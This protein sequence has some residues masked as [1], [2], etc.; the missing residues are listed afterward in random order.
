MYYKSMCVSR[1]FTGL[2]VCWSN[3]QHPSSCISI[4][5]CVRDVSGHYEAG[6]CTMN[7]IFLFWFW[8]YDLIY[9]LPFKIKVE[10]ITGWK[11]TFLHIILRKYFLIFFTYFENLMQNILIIFLPLLKLLPVLPYLP[12]DPTSCSFT[13][14]NT[15]KT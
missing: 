11:K 7:S 15:A 8:T 13:L 2:V 5:N 6:R 4:K 10:N 3:R 1:N 14:L 9:I 12:T